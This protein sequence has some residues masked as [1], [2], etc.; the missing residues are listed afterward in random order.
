RSPLTRPDRLFIVWTLVV[1][2]FFSMSRTKQPGY[3]LTGVVA[4]AVCVGRGLGYAWQNPNGRAARLLARGA[5]A[6]AGLS[7]VS[8]SALG[9]SVARG[10]ANVGNLAAMAADKR[11]IWLMWPAFLIA[12]LAVAVLGAAAQTTRR[13]GFA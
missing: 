11:S 12:L 3:I 13:A 10:A 1:I 5:L 2:L 9:L 8:A 6:L 4:A 7:V